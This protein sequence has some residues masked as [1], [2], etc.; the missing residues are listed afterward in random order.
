MIEGRSAVVDDDVNSG[1]QAGGGVYASAM[2]YNNTVSGRVR[3]T[4]IMAITRS[5]RQIVD[6]WC[7]VT[8]N[9]SYSR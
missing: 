8:Y 5:P 4:T 9:L 7:T 6:N 3:R 1:R 2:N